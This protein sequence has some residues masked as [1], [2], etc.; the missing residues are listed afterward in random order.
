MML[1]TWIY[2][3]SSQID[4]FEVAKSSMTTLHQ[5][6]ERAAVTP[7]VSRLQDVF[8]HE[9]PRPFAHDAGSK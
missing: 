9:H 2:P 4:V 6:K 3:K 5:A 8:F 7:W 1:Q